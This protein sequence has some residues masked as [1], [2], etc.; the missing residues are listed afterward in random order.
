MSAELINLHPIVSEILSWGSVLRDENT[1]IANEK[2][3]NAGGKPE[4]IKDYSDHSWD[5]TVK[6]TLEESPTTVRNY[7]K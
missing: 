5:S 2:V 4:A 7:K 1:D 6:K 3:R